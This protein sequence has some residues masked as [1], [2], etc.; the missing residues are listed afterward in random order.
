MVVARTAFVTCCVVVHCAFKSGWDSQQFRCL[1]WAFKQ[2]K[3]NLHQANGQLPRDRPTLSIAQKLFAQAGQRHIRRRARAMP[4][5]R[6]GSVP[7]LLR[8]K[9][10]RRVELVAAVPA[11]FQ[12]KAG[13]DPA[14]YRQLR[15]SRL[16]R[17]SGSW[18][19]LL[20]RP[21]AGRRA[22]PVPII[23]DPQTL[24]PVRVLKPGVER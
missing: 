19:R 2:I 20:L 22:A 17:N 13:I 9:T 24:M 5:P 16:A 8:R 11:G 18:R 23:Y 21:S 6:P 15:E 4:Q 1:L 14:A 7:F 3:A 10:K 12:R